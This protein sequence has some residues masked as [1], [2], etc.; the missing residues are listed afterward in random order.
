MKTSRKIC[1]AFLPLGLIMVAPVALAQTTPPVETIQVAPADAIKA[2]EHIYAEGKIAPSWR[3]KDVAL[4]GRDVV[5]F[6]QETG[7]VKGKKKFAAEYDDT[8]WYFK[9][10]E[11]RDAFKA[12]PEKYIPE[13]GG[14]CPVA[15]GLGEVKVGRTNQFTRHDGK[16]YMNYNRKNRSKFVEDPERY[17]LRAQ[18]NW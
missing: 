14:F 4:R 7:P 11:N 12:N 15:L 8:K 17:I 3:D 1:A 6:S 13:F 18:V 5:S 2:A 9:T 16:L 10:E